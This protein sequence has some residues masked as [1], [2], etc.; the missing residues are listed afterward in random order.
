[1]EKQA[2]QQESKA[3]AAAQ[4]QSRA[5]SRGVKSFPAATQVRSF[6]H[7][8]ISPALMSP[9]AALDLAAQIGNSAF[10]ELLHGNREVLTVAPDLVSRGGTYS[11]AYE[12][13]TM[14]P[15]LY[16]PASLAG[17]GEPPELNEWGGIST[18]TQ[19]IPT[20][21]EVVHE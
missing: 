17:A 18:A 4:K 6:L 19:A 12:I 9:E 5:A 8:G 15:A 14:P 1:M 2:Q 10:W 3:P 20:V 21:G 16:N 11:E 13:R 7:A